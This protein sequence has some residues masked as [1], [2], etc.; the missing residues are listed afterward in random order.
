MKFKPIKFTQLLSGTVLI[1]TSF[2]FA[3]NA[4]A[5]VI[6]AEAF[7]STSPTT[8]SGASV[9]QSTTNGDFTIT[10]TGAN[11]TLGNGV[12]EA[13]TWSFDYG[14]VALSGP[15]SSAILTM[16]L[17]PTSSLFVTDSF[18]IEGL[19]G[20]STA[21]FLGL[22]LGSLQT[23]SIDLLDFYTSA[24]IISEFYASPVD[25]I[26]MYYQDDAV[27][28]YARLDLTTAAAPEPLTATLLIAGLIALFCVNKKRA[29]SVNPPETAA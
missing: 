12:D 29:T 26:R 6:S 17:T 23:V 5:L 16:S 18:R 10:R 9:G 3:Q 19:T 4:S 28:S 21:V 1:L 22:S 20:I 2:F 25:Q 27:I 8:I 13:T 11:T 7:G 15:L 24:D 14:M